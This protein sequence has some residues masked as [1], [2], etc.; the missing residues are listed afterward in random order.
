M[1]WGNCLKLR[2]KLLASN[3]Q[4]PLLA[5]SNQLPLLASSYQPPLLTA[6]NQLP[7]LDQLIASCTGRHCGRVDGD[8]TAGR[9]RRE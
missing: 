2:E 1:R 5:S 6:S 9:V 4:L 7:L 8:D 3:N